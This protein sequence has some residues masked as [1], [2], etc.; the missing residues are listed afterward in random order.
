M[1][2]DHSRLDLKNTNSCKTNQAEFLRSISLLYKSCEQIWG[3]V[4]PPFTFFIHPIRDKTV[5]RG[6][7]FITQ[8][9]DRM[10]YFTILKYKLHSFNIQ[11]D[12]SALGL[13]AKPL[14]IFQ[15]HLYGQSVLSVWMNVNRVT[16][17]H[18]KEFI[19]FIF[20]LVVL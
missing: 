13:L 8:T 12:R 11:D 1:A 2:L 10:Q 19:M 15:N 17:Q 18:N 3:R 7:V 16:L 5:L 6:A 9:S 20:Y 4:N 14:K